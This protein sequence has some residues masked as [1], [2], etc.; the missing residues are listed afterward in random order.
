MAKYVLS[1]VKSNT[2]SDQCQ[3]STSFE[4][5]RKTYP[6]Q[7]CK[8]FFNAKDET[9]ENNVEKVIS[10]LSLYLIAWKLNAEIEFILMIPEWK[11]SRETYA[12]TNKTDDQTD[13]I[14]GLYRRE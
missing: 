11:G 2:T 4:G 3:K 10:A 6:H 13:A 7:V 12:E 5:M 8:Y 14:S 9:Y 1:R